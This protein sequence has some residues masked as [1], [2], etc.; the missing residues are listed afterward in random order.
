[1]AQID[2]VAHAILL[3]HEVAAGCRRV[4][5]AMIADDDVAAHAAGEVDDDVD[6]ALTDS[7]DHLAVVFR[8]HAERTRLRVAHVNVDDRSTCLGRLDRRG[9]NL[10]WRHC[11]VRALRYLGVVAG[12]G[13]SDDDIWVHGDLERRCDGDVGV[14]V[15]LSCQ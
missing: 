8:L 2:D 3:G 11:T 12:D 9:G 10:F 4:L 1:V 14:R 5:Q 13:T 6:L 15:I 7:L